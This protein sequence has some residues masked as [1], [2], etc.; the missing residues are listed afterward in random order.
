MCLKHERRHVS[1]IYVKKRYSMSWSRCGGSKC[2]ISKTVRDRAVLCIKLFIGN[3]IENIL[4]YMLETHGALHKR[5]KY[6]KLLSDGSK[7]CDFLKTT[8]N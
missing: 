8:T 5:N 4:F 1:E 7:Y 6:Q 2:D 3:F